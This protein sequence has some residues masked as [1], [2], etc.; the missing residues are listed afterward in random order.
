VRTKPVPKSPP[1]CPK[2][3]TCAVSFPF[4]VQYPYRTANFPPSSSPRLP[5]C[6]NPCNVVAAACRDYWSSCSASHHRAAVEASAFRAVASEWS[7]ALVAAAAVACDAVASLLVAVDAGNAAADAKRTGC[8]ACPET[9]PDDF[10]RVTAAA[11]RTGASPL[12]NSADDKT[13]VYSSEAAAGDAAPSDCA[14]RGAPRREA[15]TA[16]AAPQRVDR[17]GDRP[18]RQTVPSCC[19]GKVSH[20]Q[21]LSNFR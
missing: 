11:F 21:S 7:A 10:P 19:L 12:K 5:S 4:G 6:L 20:W 15:S 8:R 9:K 2:L 16:E 3:L 18:V 13:D 14:V 1:N 17:S